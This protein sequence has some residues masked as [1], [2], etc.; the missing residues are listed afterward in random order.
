MP[1][2]WAVMKQTTIFRPKDVG[3][4]YSVPRSVG[5]PIYKDP[6]VGIIRKMRDVEIGIVLEKRLR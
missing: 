2:N 6:K 5:F 4:C 3:C 1:E